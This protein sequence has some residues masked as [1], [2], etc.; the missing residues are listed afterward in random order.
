MFEAEFS[1]LEQ[2][3]QKLISE[4]QQLTAQVQQLDQK[5][6]QLQQELK[7][8]PISWKLYSYTPWSLMIKS[9]GRSKNYSN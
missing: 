3:I 5:E 9:S 8:A 7:K 1:K 2:L 6:Q 4:N